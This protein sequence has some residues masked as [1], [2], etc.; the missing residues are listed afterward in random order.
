VFVSFWLVTLLFGLINETVT[1]V[2]FQVVSW[3]ASS[4]WVE[5][6]WVNYI[7]P[8]VSIVLA[9]AV[10]YVIGLVGGNVFGRQL[11]AW[12]EAVLL[13]VPI[14]RGIYGATRQF[15]DTFSRQDGRA[16][17]GVVL[18][19]FP[20]AGTWTLGLVTG[21]TQGEIYRRIHRDLVNVFVPTTPN[22]TGGYLIF[23]PSEN[24]IRLEMSIDDAL[25]MIISGGV[26]T[27]GIGGGSEALAESM[28]GVR[29]PQG[30][31]SEA[32]GAGRRV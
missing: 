30:L 4:A 21:S 5:Q 2:L 11:L 25:K 9:V 7:A 8:L 29:P 6:A 26:L 3:F 20:R 31:P 32:S 13:R 28:A 18:V 14:V 10:I 16:F 19:E 15:I 1:P 23:V 17:S 22:P 24:V 27:P 12:L